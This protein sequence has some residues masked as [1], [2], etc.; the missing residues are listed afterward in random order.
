MVLMKEGNYGSD[1][2][3]RGIANY[4]VVGTEGSW[5]VRHDGKTENEYAT[6]EAAFEPAI[7][8]GGPTYIL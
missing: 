3:Q 8:G 6:K 2:Y 7:A 4:E 1:V 5:W